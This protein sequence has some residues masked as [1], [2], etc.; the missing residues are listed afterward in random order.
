MKKRIITL[1][2]VICL[3][4]MTGCQSEEVKSEEVK[5]EEVKN[6]ESK[7]E[8]SKN[9]LLG[10]WHDGAW[11]YYY[12]FEEQG[13]VYYKNGS[14]CNMKGTYMQD[15]KKVV[16]TFDGKE[17]IMEL[18][19]GQKCDVLVEYTE[20]TESVWLYMKEEERGLYDFKT[21]EKVMELAEKSTQLIRGETYGIK[22]GFEFCVK[23]IVIDYDIPGILIDIEAV[24]TSDEKQVYG[25]GCSTF[26]YSSGDRYGTPNNGR[27]Y[28]D[29][30]VEEKQS[31]DV[32][33]EI[34]SYYFDMESILVD[35][36]EYLNGRDENKSFAYTS[37]QINGQKYWIDI[38]EEYEEFLRN[39]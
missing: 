32:L 25:I 15:G 6:E 21:H 17:Y 12:V 10:E 28:S 34:V 7:N 22:D 18:I 9:P 31:R 39:M 27:T 23:D 3:M 14:D 29:F 2:G 24:N 33:Y 1:I 35:K 20:D 30:L 8:E 36:S 37:F 16:T 4:L 13:V 19:D 5:S 26:F 38:S 11:G